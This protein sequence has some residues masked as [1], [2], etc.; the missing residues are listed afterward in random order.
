LNPAKL[1]AASMVC[2]ALV[3]CASSSA[4]V[5]KWGDSQSDSPLLTYEFKSDGVLVM[6]LK[7][8]LVEGSY[9]IIDADTFS[10]TLPILGQDRTTEMDYSVSG[11]VLTLSADG[12]MLLLH[13]VA[14]P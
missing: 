11:D 10:M 6:G 14:A 8:I 12:N 9:R 2:L 1:I 4:L 3:A 5:G 7:D 13:R